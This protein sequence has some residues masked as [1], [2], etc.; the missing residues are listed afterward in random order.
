M[1]SNPPNKL[2]FLNTSIVHILCIILVSS[3]FI[4]FALYL[5]FG[6][7]IISL[8]R[9][10]KASLNCSRDKSEISCSLT[11][12]NSYG[13]IEQ[14]L[15]SRNEKLLGVRMEI[16]REDNGVDNWIVLVTNKKEIFLFT[17]KS[18]I[19]DQIYRLD[20]FLNNPTQNA[21][22]IETRRSNE[23]KILSM[24]PFYVI[25]RDLCFVI[26]II[27]IVKSIVDSKKYIFD[28]ENN[29]ITI[30]R[31]LRKDLSLEIGFKKIKQVNLVLVIKSDE[32][33]SEKILL[34]GNDDSDLLSIDL[35]YTSGSKIADSICSFLHLEPYQTI[36]VRL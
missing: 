32:N 15:S 27:Y 1:I 14:V 18:V 2:V 25:Y 9:L 26:P 4:L 33:M 34:I 13:N 28:K 19:A 3:P 30:K 29:R 22:K 10:N 6:D 24:S 17:H 12:T 20:S 7:L 5:T 16:S 11:G 36:E 23:R 8:S 35:H 21:V 31:V